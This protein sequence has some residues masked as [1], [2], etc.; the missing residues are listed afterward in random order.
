MKTPGA[1][2]KGQDPRIMARLPGEAGVMPTVRLPKQG[3]PPWGIA[4]GAVILAILLFAALEARRNAPSSPAVTAGTADFTGTQNNVPPLYIPPWVPPQALINPTPVPADQAPS[5]APFPTPQTIYVPQPVPQPPLIPQAVEP[6]FIPT[7]TA[8]IPTEPALVY[9]AGSQAPG[10]AQGGGADG[11]GA[12]SPAGPPGSPSILGNRTRAGVFANPGWTVPQGTLI[13]AVLETALNSTRPGLARA[14]VSRDV[15][16]FDGTR[17]LIPR[18]SRLIGEYRS[19]AAPGQNRLLVNWVRLIRPD[20][21]TIQIG[22]PGSDP[23]GGT[24]IKA[25]VNSHFFERF[26]GAILQSALDVGVNLAGRAV[27]GPVVILPGTVQQSGAGQ[28][29]NQG[30][31][32]PTLKVKQGTSIS[33]FVA[34]DLDFIGI[35]TRR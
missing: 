14:I 15:R 7:P 21:V 3:I 20:G 23:L 22:S 1:H 19:D 32:P 10:S 13:P 18:G 4:V 11:G 27:D 2:P 29:V 9:D 26:A 16:G 17:V 34:R 8:R 5:T 31:I 35:E 25:R 6:G 12:A 24:G 28:I 33:I 30:Q